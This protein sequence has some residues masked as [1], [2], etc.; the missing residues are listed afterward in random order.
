MYKLQDALID[1]ALSTQNLTQ[2]DAFRKKTTASD[3]TLPISIIVKRGYLKSTDGHALLFDCSFPV[4]LST[5]QKGSKH[6]QGSSFCTDLLDCN[7][8]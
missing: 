8:L 5:R 1:A 3:M 7:K 4:S 6:F 2:S